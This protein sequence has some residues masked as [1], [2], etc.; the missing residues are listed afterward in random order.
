[1][2]HMHPSDPEDVTIMFPFV[3][4]LLRT[5]V[6]HTGPAGKDHDPYDVFRI[7]AVCFYCVYYKFSRRE[8]FISPEKSPE[9]SGKYNLR[10]VVKEICHQYIILMTD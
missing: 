7:H 4:A 8:N 5:Y 6:T 9:E 2:I 3:P 10:L 1:M